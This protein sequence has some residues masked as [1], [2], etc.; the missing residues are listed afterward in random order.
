MYQTYAQLVAYFEAMPTLI[1]ALKS[2][3]VGDDEAILTQ[4]NTRIKYPHLRVETPPVHF[5]GGDVNPAKRFDFQVTVITNEP[6]IS[7]KAANARLS[8]MLEIIE[9]VYSL[10]VADDKNLFDL[11]WKD[12]DAEP[13]VKWSADNDWGWR[14]Q[15]SIDLPR[16]FCS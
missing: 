7:T 12:D 5:V 9:E 16:N 2:A 15:I 4:Q 6:K 8:E 14:L 11:V 13:I 10:L 1:P 3:L